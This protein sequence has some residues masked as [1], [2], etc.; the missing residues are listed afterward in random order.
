MPRLWNKGGVPD[1]PVLKKL[2]SNYYASHDSIDSDPMVVHY[3]ERGEDVACRPAIQKV[4][5]DLLEQ[6]EFRGKFQKAQK[7][8][9]LTW[10]LL[11]GTLCL[12]M[13]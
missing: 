7:K 13:V 1:V 12:L 10:R 4:A 11:M 8:E 5:G 9:V 2:H 3:L 6:L